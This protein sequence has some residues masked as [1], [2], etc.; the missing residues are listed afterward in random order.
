MFVC[1]FVLAIEIFFSPFPQ[2]GFHGKEKGI[3]FSHCDDGANMSYDHLELDHTHTVLTIGIINDV[4][5]QH[6]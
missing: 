3:D 6:H 5:S 4:L 1:L 2:K